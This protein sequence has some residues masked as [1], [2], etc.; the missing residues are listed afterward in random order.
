MARV[1]AVSTA[2][3]PFAS[4]EFHTARAVEGQCHLCM[5]EVVEC[6]MLLHTEFELGDAG[7]GCYWDRTSPPQQAQ[8]LS[9]VES[10]TAQAWNVGC[11]FS[12]GVSWLGDWDFT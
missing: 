1:P 8:Y 5:A 12:R 11:S 2:V 9:W 3:S 4:S 6:D 7:E 10:V